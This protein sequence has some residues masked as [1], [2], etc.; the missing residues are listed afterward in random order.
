M[1][2]LVMKAVAHALLNLFFLNPG[3]KSFGEK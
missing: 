3:N 2:G 1:E